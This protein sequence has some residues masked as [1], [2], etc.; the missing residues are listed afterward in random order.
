MEEADK[1]GTAQTAHT[2]AGRLEQADKWLLNPDHDDKGLGKRAI[3]LIIHEGRKV[4]YN[5]LLQ[6]F[7]TLF[8]ENYINILVIILDSFNCKLVIFTL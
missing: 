8:M 1:S 7:F 5:E 3:A 6:S 4:R 2:V